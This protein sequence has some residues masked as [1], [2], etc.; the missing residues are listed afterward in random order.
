M[1]RQ[2]DW[3]DPLA[4]KRVRISITIVLWAIGIT[5][6]YLNHHWLI[7]AFNNLFN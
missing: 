5:L 6:L 4:M 7:T 2:H 3:Y 1:V